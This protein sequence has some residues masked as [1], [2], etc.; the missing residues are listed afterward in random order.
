[1]PGDWEVGREIGREIGIGMQHIAHSLHSLCYA[2][3][4]L[5]HR[6][7]VELA[8]NWMCIVKQMDLTWLWLNAYDGPPSPLSPLPSLLA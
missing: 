3:P 7:R 6:S 1:M 4:G 5:E 2:V 8:T